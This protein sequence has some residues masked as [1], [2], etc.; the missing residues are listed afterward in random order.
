M[1]NAEQK[2]AMQVAQALLGSISGQELP[3]QVL[4]A[5][6]PSPTQPVA[7]AQA[8]APPPPSLQRANAAVPPPR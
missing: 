7:A 4:L 6:Q 3:P 5:P 1:S 2:D 8:Q